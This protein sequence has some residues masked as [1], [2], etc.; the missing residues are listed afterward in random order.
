LHK[1]KVRLIWLVDEDA[2]EGRDYTL[3]SMTPFWWLTSDQDREIC[4][5]AQRGVNSRAY[6]PGPLSTYKEYNVD[7]F[8]RWYLRQLKDHIDR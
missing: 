2:V 4:E 3:E 5:N 1:T 6:T 7:R 8:L